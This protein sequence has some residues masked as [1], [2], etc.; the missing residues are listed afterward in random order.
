MPISEKT[1]VGGGKQTGKLS[2]LPR[3]GQVG[4]FEK[5]FKK[6][7]DPYFLSNKKLEFLPLTSA[8]GESLLVLR[9]ISPSLG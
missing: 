9:T 5:C 2:M 1:R 7:A 3:L 6:S 8:S 4:S